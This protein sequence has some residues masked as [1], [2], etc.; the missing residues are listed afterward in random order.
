MRK[1]GKA[2]KLKYLKDCLSSNSNRWFLAVLFFLWSLIA[3][4]SL[5]FPSLYQRWDLTLCWKYSVFLRENIV[6]G[7]SILYSLFMILRFRNLTSM[8]EFNDIKL[9]RNIFYVSFCFELMLNHLRLFEKTLI[10]PIF[11]FLSIK[12][13]VSRYFN[14]FDVH[15][16]QRIWYSGIQIWYILHSFM[17]K[18]T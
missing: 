8:Y 6:C 5:R 7:Y 14:I 13:F 10:D 4:S 17:S 3:V 18:R 1:R 9:F 2:K 16:V 11:I 12:A 15:N